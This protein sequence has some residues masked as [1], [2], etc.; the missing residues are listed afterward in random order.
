MEKII[1]RKLELED[2]PEIINIYEIITG[3]NAP[4]QDDLESQMEY[5]ESLLCIGAEINEKLV[6][7]IFGR[8]DVSG[9]FGEKGIVGWIGLLGVHPDFRHLNVG[10]E[11]GEELLKQFQGLSISTIRTR[12]KNTN[13]S[14]LKYFMN[15]GL[16][17]S[18]WTM[19]ELN[20]END[21]N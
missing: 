21:Q 6:G 3:D 18:N 12:V 9:Q 2:I 1:T 4:E 17:P 10:R 15:L 19:L 20:F 8:T 13:A 7:F 14:L 16:A 5:G 11:L